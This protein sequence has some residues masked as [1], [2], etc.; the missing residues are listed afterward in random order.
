MRVAPKPNPAGLSLL[1]CAFIA[2]AA[3]LVSTFGPARLESQP[4]ATPDY[5]NFEAL[6]VHPVALTPDG[7]KLVAINT[8]DC[9]V[10]VFA[11]GTGSLLSLGEIEVGLEPISAAAQNDSIVWVVNHVSDDVSIVNLNRMRVEGTLRVGDAPTDVVFAG[12]PRRA[13][14]CVGGEDAV[15][16]Y[17]LTGGGATLDATQPI[18]ARHPRSLAVNGPEVWV[19]ALDAGNRTTI[20]SAAE[21]Q[22]G[23]GPPPSSQPR[24][25][26][27]PPDGPAAPAVGLI[28]QYVG[29]NWVDER[30]ASEKTWNAFIPYTLPD[31]DVTV[32]SAAT[33][34]ILRTVSDVGTNLFNLTAVASGNVYVTNT[35]AFNRTRNEIDVMGRFAQNRVTRVSGAVVTPWHLNSHIDYNTIPGPPQERALSLSQ[36]MDLA[37]NATETK[38]YVAALGS[39]KVGVVNPSTGSVTNRIPTSV[40]GKSTRNG[41]TGLALDSGRGQIYVLNRF[42]NSVAVLSTATETPIYERS[43]AISN[44]RAA[45]DPLDGFTPEGPEILAGRRFLYDGTLSAHGDLACASCHIGGNFDNIAWDLSVPSGSLEPVP[46]SLQPPPPI[47][48]IP[49]FDPAKGPMVTQSLRGLADTSPFHW[50]G[51]RFDF[52]RFNPAFIGLMGNNDTLPAADMASYSAFIMTLRYP[53]NPN[54]N[55]DRTWPN[56]ATPAASPERGRQEFDNVPHDGGLTCDGC[57]A[58]PT[59]T[60]RTLIPAQALQESQAFKVPQL[61]NMYEK[62]G[63][64]DAAGPQKRGFGFMHDGSMDDLFSFLQL[65]VFTF[66]SNQVRRD[67]EAFL[68][69]FDTGMAPSVGRQV[70][71][72][73]S[74]KNDLGTVAQLDSLGATSEAGNCDVIV[75]YFP[76]D[77]GGE[78]R[79]YLRRIGG[80]LESDYD[81]EGTVA[82]SAF[83]QALSGSGVAVYLGVPP[84][85]G[86]RMALDRDRDGFKNRY[87]RSLGSDP[88][89]PA[90]VPY[91]TAVEESRSPRQV[92][93]LGQNAPNPFNP[94]TVI[95]YEVGRAARV[96]LQVFDVRGRLVRTLVDASQRPG[97]YDARWDGRDAGGRGVASG[98]YYYRLRV[99]NSSLS[100]GMLL[101]K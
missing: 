19:A 10:E 24:W 70:V 20:L 95:P 59:G 96:R 66:A 36:P 46:A 6:Q 18:F 39:D 40:V 26:P 57:H 32:L 29:G 11:P 78:T 81:P 4:Q 50:R 9:R 15:K 21:V 88:A 42:S 41:P 2:L 80:M 62:T 90:S 76:G 100:R 53:P 3:S 5:A 74:N 64:T 16:I 25:I 68:L 93:R 34:G 52:T 77:P 28:V 91:V 61:R 99:G 1:A 55:L 79:H 44:A 72:N 43:L 73:A 58:F 30:P 17:S 31:H 87:E 67:V 37:I 35:E 49:P 54:Q 47:P 33:G 13:F 86:V 14:V 89:D 65:P 75:T 7:S 60:N 101:L 82:E 22:A 71:V 92:T 8:P 98:R 48:P 63:F 83:R 12:S 84:A 97:R 38:L 56:P 69:S 94:A 45:V 27:P 85:S 23:G 51:D